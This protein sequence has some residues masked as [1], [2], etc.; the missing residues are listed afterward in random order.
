MLGQLVEVPS[1]SFCFLSEVEG[2]S[3]VKS[4]D[5]DKV[6]EAGKRHE[7]VA[8]EREGGM[9]LGLVLAGRIPRPAQ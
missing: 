7:V 9:D 6:L 8:Y 2:R 4:E 3:S 1:D 5:G